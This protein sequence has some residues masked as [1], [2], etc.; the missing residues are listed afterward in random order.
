MLHRT[1]AAPGMTAV[2]YA[3]ESWFFASS[4]Y[5]ADKWTPLVV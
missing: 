4:V 3:I 1:A 2:R 5:P